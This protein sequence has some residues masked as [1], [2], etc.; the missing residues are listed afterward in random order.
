MGETSDTRA[1]GFK[2]LCLKLILGALAAIVGLVL[3]RVFGGA[4]FLVATLIGLVP[5]M[6]E[7]SAKKGIVGAVLG[8][9]G[10]YV[11]AHVGATV[12]D[13][14]QGVPFGHWAVTGGFIG[15][16]SAIS[17]REGLWR[18]PR[19]LATVFGAGCGLLL[20]AIFGFSGDIIGLAAVF[21][22]SDLPSFI[23][24]YT[25]EFSLVCAGIFINLGA[26][27]GSALEVRLGKKD[28]NTAETT[29]GA[30]T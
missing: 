6:A 27:A 11:G 19:L 28:L 8:F 4:E 1:C 26:A 20:G 17:R 5:G 9:V 10:Y 25:T 22:V 18:S 12:G 2:L 16:T 7:K 13:S 14:G 3:M 15:L 23:Y 29:E 24:M 30:A 21:T